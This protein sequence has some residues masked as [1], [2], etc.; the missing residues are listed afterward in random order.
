MTGSLAPWS[1]PPA[2]DGLGTRSFGK[3]SV[4]TIIPP[5][6]EGNWSVEK[7]RPHSRRQLLVNAAIAASR[8]SA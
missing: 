6:G 4:Q 2:R 8:V 1:L 5:M 3:G 7:H